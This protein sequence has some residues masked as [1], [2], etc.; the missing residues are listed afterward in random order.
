MAWFF[1]KF[2]S[3]SYDLLFVHYMWRDRCHIYRNF[4]VYHKELLVFSLI[5]ILIVELLLVIICRQWIT[6]DKH[7]LINQG[8]KGIPTEVK[9]A[10]RIILLFYFYYCHLV[11]IVNLLS[12][13][14]GF[15]TPFL[16]FFYT[17]CLDEHVSPYLPLF[18]VIF[19]F[20]WFG[21]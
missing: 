10:S 7:I 6:I 4:D 18:E 2:L 5:L 13:L 11:L 8:A 3:F 12:F 9:F 15:I 16:K 20:F 17:P 19:N 14:F 21:D 1:K